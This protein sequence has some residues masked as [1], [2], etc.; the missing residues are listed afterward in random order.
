MDAAAIENGPYSVPAEAQKIYREQILGNPLIRNSLPLGIEKAAQSI[1]F[2]GSDAPTLPVNLRFAESISSLKALEASLLNLVLEE[3]LFIM[4]FALWALDPAGANINAGTLRTAEGRAQLARYLP[5]WERR[6]S[7]SDAGI[8]YQTAVTNIYA[9]KDGRYFHLHC[10]PDPGPIQEALGLPSGV[11]CET[12]DASKQPYKQAVGRLTA[13]ELQDL[14]D[15]RRQAGTVCLTK[16]EYASSEHGRANAHIG[17]F[18]IIPHANVT[19]SK[20]SRVIAAPVIGRS[21]AELGASVMRITAHHLPDTSGLHLDTNHGKWNACLDLRREQDRESLRE[22]IRGADVF[23]QGYR[24]GAL[25]KHGFGEQHVL[26]LCRNRKDRGGI[27]YVAENCYGWHGPWMV[28]DRPLLLNHCNA[29]TKKK[30]RSAMRPQ[31][32]LNYYSRWLLSSVGTYPQHVW[33]DLRRRSGIPQFEHHHSMEH[34]IPTVFPWLLR[35]GILSKSEFYT[36]YYA[37]NLA[38]TVRIV[39]PVLF[40]P[41]GEVE[42]GY[43]VGTRTNGVDMAKWPEDLGVEVV[44]GDS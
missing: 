10:S 6:F 14:V 5:S 16:E 40:Y 12:A 15:D 4:S 25:D 41:G 42:P 7:S 3:K 20:L 39:A 29:L 11:E 8:R 27:I 23:I 35:S 1:V 37:K 2:T 44:D 31:L 36:E 30:K 28:A 21:L 19:W 32:A 26:E 18:E 17:L 13:E 9:T 24:A 43:Q 33:E 38:Q 34:T 22:L